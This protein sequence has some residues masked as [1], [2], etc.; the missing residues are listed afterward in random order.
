LAE[1]S[2]SGLTARKMLLEPSR[3]MIDDRFNRARFWKQVTGARDDFQPALTTDARKR[4]LVEFD[5]AMI[6]SAD[7][8]KC[9]G[10][11]LL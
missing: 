6:I 7:D 4:L 3:G 9:R 2:W 8:K 11:D 1:L 5:D 10:P